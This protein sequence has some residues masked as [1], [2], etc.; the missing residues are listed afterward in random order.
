MSMKFRPERP[1]SM[2]RKKG[3]LVDFL[4]GFRALGGS[5]LPPK[6]FNIAGKNQPISGSILAKHTLC[7]P[8]LSL[9]FRGGW[10]WCWS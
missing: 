4:G 3:P 1:L 8:T 2:G 9:M 10:N 6:S 5:I 7:N